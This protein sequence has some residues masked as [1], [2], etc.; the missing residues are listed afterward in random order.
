M[1]Y[2][3]PLLFL[4]SCSAGWHIKKAIAKDPSILQ[5]DTLVIRDTL[6]VVTN[7]VSTDSTFILSKDTVVIQKDNLTIRH[8]Y[9]KD[10]VYIWGECESDTIKVEYYKEIPVEKLVYNESWKM[11]KYFWWLIIVGVVLFVLNRLLPTSR[12]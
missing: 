1:K 6:Q 7:N 2:L 10:S 8:Y 12:N 11:P 3:I 5:K 9:H 4:T